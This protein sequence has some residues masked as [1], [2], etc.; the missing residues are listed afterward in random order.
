MCCILECTQT[1]A[2][3]TPFFSIVKGVIYKI[4]ISC[5]W[6]GPR[7]SRA[8]V[9][10]FVHIASTFVY[11]ITYYLRLITLDTKIISHK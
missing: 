9:Q 4:G 8:R 11:S 7:P 3:R 10:L 2:T 5:D 6:L 1:M